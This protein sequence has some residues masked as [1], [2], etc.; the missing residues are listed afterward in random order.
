MVRRSLLFLCLGIFIQ[1]SRADVPNGFQEAVVA[2][3]LV[4]PAALAA[5]PDGRIFIAEKNLGTIRV[6]KNNA[7]LPTPFLDVHDFLD[8]NQEFDNINERGIVGIAFDPQFQT[9]NYVYAFW[10]VAEGNVSTNRVTRFKASGDVAVPDFMQMVIDGLDCPS[11]IHNA[12]WIGFSPS[13]G[14]LYVAVGDGG[15]TPERAQN[16][17]YLN[18]KIL[19]LNSNGTIPTNN[20]FV[21]TPGARPEIFAL[22][23]R[24]PWR[25]RFHPDGRLFCADVGQDAYE[26]VNLVTNG[27]N[28]GWP[29]TE[30]PFSQGSFPSLKQPFYYYAHDDNSSSIIGGDFG[31]RTNFP[32]LYQSSYFFGDWTGGWIKRINLNSPGTAVPFADNVGAITD[33]V[34][35]DDGS[36]YYTEIYAGELR[37]ISAI[38]PGQNNSPVAVIHASPTEG[39]PP[40]NVAFS[41]SGST[42]PDGDP[43]TFHWN[44]G[45]GSAS[46]SANPTH[47]YNQPGSYHV[48]LTVSDGSPTSGP[49]SASV[50]ILVGDAPQ[51]TITE[52]F[53]GSQFIAGELIELQGSASD[54]RGPIPSGNLHWSVVFHH[55]THTHPFIPDLPGST[56]E[57]ITQSTGETATNIFYRIKL[58]ATNSFGLTG[59]DTVDIYPK[60]VNVTIDTSPPGLV[61]TL[62]GQPYVAPVT[63]PSVVGFSRSIGTST[64]QIDDGKSYEFFNWSNGGA[65]QHTITTPGENTTIVATFAE[66]P[67]GNPPDDGNGDGD[68]S[69]D[70]EDDQHV[71]KLTSPTYT[72][73]NGFLQMVNILEVMNVGSHQLRIT[74]TLFANDGS[75]G[76]KIS[77]ILE[78]GVQQDLIMNDLKGFAPDSYGLIRLDFVGE[79]AGRVSSY[80]TGET[81]GAYDFAF[82]IPLAN[83]TVGDSAVTFNTYQPSASI[84]D[85]DNVVANW[86]TIVNLDRRAGQFTIDHFDQI[87]TLLGTTEVIV[88][89]FGRRDLPGGHQ[90]G[91]QIV[92]LNVIR[93]PNVTVPYLAQL[94]RYGLG[95]ISSAGISNYQF[96]FPLRATPGHNGA[97]DTQL[98]IASRYGALNWVEL[99]NV[100]DEPVALRSRFFGSEGNLLDVQSIMLTPYSQVHFNA[101]SLLKLEE[102]GQVIFDS[103]NTRVNA[104]VS[105]SM[106]YYPDPRTG[107]IAAISG[108]QAREPVGTLFGSYNLFLQ[109]NNSWVIHNATDKL[110]NVEFEVQGVSG[111]AIRPYPLPPFFSVELALDNPELFGTTA[112]TYGLVAIR[113]DRRNAIASNVLRVH[114]DQNGFLD[115]VFPV[116]LN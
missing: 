43:I 61:V 107:G 78:P 95:D 31:A 110:V 18:G 52:P 39:A 103:L 89:S 62:D 54:I 27:S 65:E 116:P 100:T 80:R 92:G 63:T 82:A 47:L 44:F 29:L 17:Q 66:L 50:N 24:N 104:I 8:S 9:N 85:Q 37:R 106:F 20:P 58:E 94:V 30:G 26:E 11:F 53:D 49:A 101:S 69:G 73:W 83:P 67:E 15:S 113:S 38:L 56:Q 21:G 99:V 88:P 16:L 98:T 59:S 64:M 77:L 70:N 13:D 86:L 55:D 114:R 2:G 14:K 35:G 51:V 105:Q 79:L 40:L 34:I 71:S 74:G 33:L 1:T 72:F 28:Y 7:L 96:A 81:S 91:P 19:R 111:S 87:G 60:L 36:L 115:F 93:P 23:F 76:D 48:T 84:A 4:T 102:V 25:C 5:A 112:D 46:N 75:V 109:M 45:D 68:T 42:D 90:F 10:T 6:F 3:D 57:F 41:S 97:N 12:G 108:I 22:G 32:S